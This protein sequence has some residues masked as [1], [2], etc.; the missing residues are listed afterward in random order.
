MR[1]PSYRAECLLSESSLLNPRGKGVEKTRTTDGACCSC[2]RS[3]LVYESAARAA[4]RGHASV[5]NTIQ[6]LHRAIP[7]VVRKHSFAPGGAEP[8]ALLRIAENLQ[9]GLRILAG[10]ARDQKMLLWHRIDSARC[11]AAGDDGHAR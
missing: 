9:H 3:F 8:P 1:R 11:N 6:S 5:D 2:R 7:G 10:I 4:P